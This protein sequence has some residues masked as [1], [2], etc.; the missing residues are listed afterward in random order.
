MT[1]MGLG[2][3]V[4]VV[5]NNLI[6]QTCAICKWDLFSLSLLLSSYLLTKGLRQGPVEASG[7]VQ[8][9]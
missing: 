3:D 6:F 8:K 5:D 1:N 7:A 4:S 2:L 9:L